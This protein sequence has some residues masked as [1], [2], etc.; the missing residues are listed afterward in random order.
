MLGYFTHFIAC[1]RHVLGLGH[2]NARPCNRSVFFSPM[3]IYLLQKRFC[4][5]NSI[6]SNNQNRFLEM[7][8]MFNY[9][10]FE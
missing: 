2:L 8:L 9:L 6:G 10:H 3:L 7:N 4:R 5:E 1:I